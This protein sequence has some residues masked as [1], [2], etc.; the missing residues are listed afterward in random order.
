MGGL[1]FLLPQS[2]GSWLHPR[3]LLCS[4][5]A[6]ASQQLRRSRRRSRAAI[7]GESSQ[8][9]CLPASHDQGQVMIFNKYKTRRLYCFSSWSRVSLSPVATLEVESQSSNIYIIGSE[10]KLHMI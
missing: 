7:V 4:G 2:P 1:Q 9:V 10:L 3:S 5:P 8:Q 6:G